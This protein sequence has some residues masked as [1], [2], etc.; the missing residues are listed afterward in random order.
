MQDVCSLTREGKLPFIL[1]AEFH[2]PPSLW[3]DMSMHGG[4]L[5]IRELGASVVAELCSSCS[6]GKHTSNPQSP[7]PCDPCAG[8]WSGVRDVRGWVLQRRVAGHYSW[9]NVSACEACDPGHSLVPGTDSCFP[10]ASGRFSDTVSA[11]SGLACESGRDSANASSTRCTDCDIGR[12]AK[13][14]RACPGC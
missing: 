9:A 12:F 14:S 6:S 11:D 5:W 4:S 7:R 3:Q 2:F 1:G 8:R 10:C 13:M